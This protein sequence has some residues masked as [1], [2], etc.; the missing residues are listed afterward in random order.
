MTRFTIIADAIKRAGSTHSDKMVAALEKTDWEG[1]I[2]RIQFYG[3]D[4][5]FTHGLKYGK[6][7]ITGLMLQWQDGKQVSGLAEGSGKGNAQV[8][9]LRESHSQLKAI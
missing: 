5:Q 4:D 2:G 7:I 3:K 8:P 9:E 1:T 6:G